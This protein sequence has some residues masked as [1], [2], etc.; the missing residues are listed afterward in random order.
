MNLKFSYRIVALN[1]TYKKSEKKWGC[2]FLQCLP[3]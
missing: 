2:L 3:N 1:E